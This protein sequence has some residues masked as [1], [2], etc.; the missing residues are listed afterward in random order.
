MAIRTLRPIRAAGFPAQALYSKHMSASLHETI[1]LN[2][3]T[4]PLRPKLIESLATAPRD[5]LH[6]NFVT[7]ASV[8]ALPKSTQRTKLKAKWEIAFRQALLL[9]GYG[10]DGINLTSTA[11][12]QGLVGR[13]E[14]VI[15]QGRGMDTAH[16]ELVAQCS[17]L[18]TALEGASAQE[19]SKSIGNVVRRVGAS[20]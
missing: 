9:N 19:R 13:L 1:I 3:R 14:V 17:K 18:I 11:A 20:T 2:S 12:R 4:H 15:T 7:D 10:I 16:E 6:W 8:K 5:V